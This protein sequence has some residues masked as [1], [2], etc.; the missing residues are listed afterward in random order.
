MIQANAKQKQ[1]LTDITDLVNEIGCGFLYGEEYEG[2]V[3]IQRHH[4]K[5]KSYK[6][7]KIHVGCDFVIPVPYQLHDPNE[8]HEFHVGHC[9][10]AF[11]KRF[12]T[13]RSL[14][15]TLIQTMIEN[16]YEVPSNEVLDAIQATS[17]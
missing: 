11:V 1:F 17:A 16:G 10:K 6:Q 4:V 9:K 7:N 13:Q 14:Y 12:G 5:G 15:A 3:S 8:K 2:Y